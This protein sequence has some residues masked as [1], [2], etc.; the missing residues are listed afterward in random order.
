MSGQVCVECQA[1]FV[2]N[3]RPGL[4]SDDC[5]VSGQV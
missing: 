4:T 2:L 1:R 5:R 3:V